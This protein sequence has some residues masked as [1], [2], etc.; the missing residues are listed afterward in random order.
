MTDLKG[1]SAQ[2]DLRQTNDAEG[3]ITCTVYS[4]PMIVDLATIVAAAACK[5][6]AKL[7]RL[8]HPWRSPETE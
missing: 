2:N 4:L 7:A 1:S 8:E 5:E 6:K 3:R